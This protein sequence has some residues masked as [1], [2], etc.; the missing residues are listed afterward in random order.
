MTHVE[1][2]RRRLEAEK[3]SPAHPAFNRIMSVLDKGDVDTANEYIDLAAGGQSL[4]E[5]GDLKDIFGTFF[6][7]A[8]SEIDNFLSD[9]HQ[10]NSLLSRIETQKGI[11]GVEMRNVPDAQ[12][13]EAT[14]LLEA[15]FALKKTKRANKD[16]LRMLFERL[17]FEVL[18]VSEGS[19]HPRAWI[20]LQTKA[21]GHR[22]QCPV[23]YFGSLA[24]GNYRIL[25]IW[26]RP[27]EEEIVNQV[28]SGRQGSPIVVLYFGRLTEQKRRDL[29]R[30]SRA[31][32][33]SFLLI[34]EI[35]IVYLCGERGVRMPVLFQCALPFTFVNPYTTT[36]SLVPPEMFY[37]R[38][39]ERTQ[40]IDPMGSCFVYGGRQLGK[41]ALLLSIRN[42]FH[43][44]AEGRIALWIDLKAAG[45]T[46]DDL[47]LN[48]A[49]AF[50]ELPNAD[51]DLG[52]S[53]SEQRLLERLQAW[54]SGDERRRILLLL[55][56]ADRFLESDSK[57]AF[58][59]TSMLKGLMER[60]N[61]RFKVVF[62]GLH[63]VQRTTKQ[64]NH[65]LAHFGEP[66]CVG[67]LLN[68]G[69][70]KEARALIERPLWSMGFRF[71]SPDLITRVLSRTNYYPSLIQLYCN[72]LFQ[73]LTR[74]SAVPF[75]WHTSP[76]YVITTKHVEDAY[77][78]RELRNAIRERFD[79]TLNLDVRYR[80]IAL[81]IA[82]YNQSHGEN[83]A[84]GMFVSDIRKD[85]VYFWDRGFRDCRSEEDFRVLLEE[86]V[87]LGVLREVAGRFALRTPN[88]LSLLGTQDEIE[89]KL[90]HSSLEAPP[91][92]FE[93]HLFRT[94]DQEQNWKRNPLTVLQES[95]LHVDKNAVTVLFGTRAAGLDDL[96][97][98]LRHSFGNAFY[99]T[100]GT[101]LTD[102]KQFQK[103]LG[104]VR[105]KLKSGTTVV[106]VQDCPWTES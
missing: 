88:I 11:P 90:E 65:P 93:A 33:L 6:P 84:D 79:L 2:V 37:G 14:D 53:R 42:E 44:P 21:L 41:T 10:S 4:P 47:W 52:E 100:F 87:G 48:L 45:A 103:R 51:I 96:N 3:I 70:S 67:P 23:P 19:G 77:S 86:M 13:R 78:S 85:A 9:S 91:P 15:W 56:E 28:R 94:S 40:I 43:N 66:I 31:D 68:T 82:F 106:L 80:V 98:F 72:Q 76:P 30:L 104:E 102:R 8:A 16:Q 64:Q 83:T 38:R 55:D 99:V 32:H 61:R 25:C 89:S 62:A 27:S 35:S 92:P 39:Y 69:E 58:K 101:E 17:G 75:D 95:E 24:N 12:V 97:R 22:D 18:T 60:T 50:R 29:A 74:E 7:Q 20:A 59:R 26:D 36:A 73:F 46:Q 49:R 5:T 81:I 105:E 63:N 71:E 57:D 1:Q 54:L 34:D